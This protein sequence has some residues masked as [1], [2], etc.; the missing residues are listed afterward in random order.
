M[1]K[2]NLALKK[3]NFFPV[4]LFYGHEFKAIV[5]A[6]IFTIFGFVFAILATLAEG[7]LPHFQK[8]T[9]Q[10]A[11][12]AIF[13]LIIVQALAGFFRPSPNPPRGD[14]SND[15]KDAVSRHSDSTSEDGKVREKSVHEENQE[16]S[17]EGDSKHRSRWIRQYCE[18]VHR[19]LGVTLLVLGW[20]NCQSGIVLQS[21]KFEQDDE[22]TLTTIF[23]SI[24]GVIAG[25]IVLIGYVIRLE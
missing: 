7:D 11:G 8:E 10:K 3:L 16:N 1:T 24:A 15:Q 25:A 2:G 9:H 20:Y 17:S 14:C 12:L 21:E 23:W 22:Q 19:F 4:L 6:V 13:M 18:Y 5:A